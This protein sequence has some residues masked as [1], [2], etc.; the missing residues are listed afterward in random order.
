MIGKFRI[1]IVSVAVCVI[2]LS[3]V[4]LANAVERAIKIA[5]NG[6][7]VQSESGAFL[8]KGR[9]FVPVRLIAEELGA[10]VQ[11]DEESNTVAIQGG[12][13]A[14]L[15][16]ITTDTSEEIGIAG[17]LV[18]A[19]DVKKVLDD[20][21]D[22]DLAD[23]RQGHNGGDIL[24]NDP[25]VVDIRDQNEYASSHIPGAIWIAYSERMAERDNVAKLKGLLDKHI[26]AGGKNEIVI[27]CYT[28]N[29]SGL[30]AGVL[31]TRGLPVKSLMYGFDIAWRGTKFADRPIKA[32]MEDSNGQAVECGG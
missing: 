27:Y 6:K 17:N 13:D 12:G 18:R 22:N 4:A 8:S 9:V 14:Y 26:A 15:K 3:G 31:G 10:Q 20:D 11:W 30:V 7:Q 5:V 21:G 1:A 32:N 16:G 25:L 29:T 19:A 23:Y 24:D 2:F 28:G